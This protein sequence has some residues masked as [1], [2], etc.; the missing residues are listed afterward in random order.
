VKNNKNPHYSLIKPTKNSD[1]NHKNTK[2][3]TF[4][5]ESKL[6]GFIK[7]NETEKTEKFKKRNEKK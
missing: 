3:Y 4:L 2:K 6:L 5:G 1:K 7:R